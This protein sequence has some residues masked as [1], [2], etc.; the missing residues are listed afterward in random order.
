MQL[1]TKVL[2]ASQDSDSRWTLVF[3]RTDER[4][5]HE[6]RSQV[7][8]RRFDY[9]VVCNGLFSEPLIPEYSGA[10][11]FTAAG[12]QLIHTSQLRSVDLAKGK[13]VAVVGFGK[14]ALD[15]ATALSHV[16]TS[17]TIIAR[18]LIWKLPRVLMNVLPYQYLLLT[19]FGEAVFSCT[20]RGPVSGAF[21]MIRRTV[22]AALGWVADRQNGLSQ[23][24][25]VPKGDFGT[26]SCSNFSL[27]TNDFFQQVRA[28]SISVHRD[29]QIANLGRSAD[30]QP[31]ASLCDGTLLQV[32]AIIAGTG[33]RQNA[34]FLD[35]HTLSRITETTSEGRKFVLYR[36][37]KPP[38]MDH[39]YFNGY[40]ASMFCPLTAG[41]YISNHTRPSGR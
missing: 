22:M 30:G 37:I 8:D 15:V 31:C 36:S 19:R 20:K 38:S 1:R 39:I 29:Q 21:S 18:R 12:G 32:D 26:I 10:G 23:L 25:L 24:N 3:T 13:R 27:T 7:Q 34:S 33:W 17:T 5:R 9:L 6:P 14:S 40:G 2:R 4:G 16:S 35:E 11:E 28:G 41:V